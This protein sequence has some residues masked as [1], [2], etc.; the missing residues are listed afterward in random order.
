MA[1]ASLDC[2]SFL[3]KIAFHLRKSVSC[4]GMVA[5]TETLTSINHSNAE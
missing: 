1:T 5:H 4:L 2:G 3:A